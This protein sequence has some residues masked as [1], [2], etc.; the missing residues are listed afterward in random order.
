MKTRS[1]SRRMVR[2]TATPTL[3]DNQRLIIEKAEQEARVADQSFAAVHEREYRRLTAHWPK[4]YDPLAPFVADCAA[5]VQRLRAE[6]EQ[7][8]REFKR[9]EGDDEQTGRPAPG[10][11]SR[12]GPISGEP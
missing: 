3:L 2:V 8:M 12:Q 5:E 6:R 7:R 1:M 10:G 11:R 4:D 9:D